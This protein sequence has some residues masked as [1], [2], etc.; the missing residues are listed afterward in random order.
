MIDRRKFMLASGLAAMVSP[1]AGFAIDPARAA[2][3]PLFRFGVI[4][5]PQ[6]AAKVPNP[7]SDGGL[8]RYYSNTLWKLSEAV[9]A[10]NKEDLAFVITLG[11]IIERDWESYSHV[12]PIYGKLKAR[13]LYLLGNHDYEIGADFRDALLHTVGMESTHYDFGNGGY[14]FVVLDGNDVS[15][16]GPPDG[17]PRRQLAQA[18]IDALKAKGAPN[19]QPW[20]GSISDQQFAWLEETVAKAKAAGEKV[21]LLGHYPIYPIGEDNA[22]DSERLTDFVAKSPNVV[23][24]FCGHHHLGNYAELNGKHFLNFKGM[25]TTPTTTAYAVVEAYPDRLEVRGV[26]REPSRTLKIA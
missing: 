7:K 24:Y 18:R 10:L 14:R 25:V 13:S 4:A 11:D 8:G 23:A 19:A 5:D 3:A 2:D 1:F 9:E 12:L 6:Y 15:L 26:D 21:V 22:L 20:N 17:D 16:F